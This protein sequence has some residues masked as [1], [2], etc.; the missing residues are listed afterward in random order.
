MINF[1]STKLI[2]FGLECMMNTP[3]LSESNR[4]NPFTLWKKPSGN[5][6]FSNK[7]GDNIYVDADMEELPII[8]E[9]SLAP[10]Q[11]IE[12]RSEIEVEPRRHSQDVE[13]NGGNVVDSICEM[14]EMPNYSLL[15]NHQQQ[16]KV[17]KSNKKIHKRNIDS[18][19]NKYKEMRI[20]VA[21]TGENFEKSQDCKQADSTKE[22]CESQSKNKALQTKKIQQ[23][24]AGNKDSSIS[25]KREMKLKLK[26]S[27][28]S[29]Q[30]LIESNC[31]N[32]NSS[33]SSVVRVSLRIRNK[34]SKAEEC[35]GWTWK[36]SQWIKL[37][38]ECFISKGFCSPSWSWED[39]FNM[40]ENEEEITKIRNK[41]ASRNPH[42]FKSKVKVE[43]TNLSS[44]EGDQKL[45]SQDIKTHIKGWNWKRSQW[46]N[47]Y[48]ECHQNGAKCTELW[49]WTEWKNKGE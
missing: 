11:H 18:R 3:N 25:K 15:D 27:E 24:E 8:R 45:S 21:K 6:E 1:K 7:N 30:E 14:F 9:F 42:A 5:Y 26:A 32:L 19:W 12:E 48:W 47:N 44:I 38:C 37:Y 39:W 10:H 2:K 41:I 49:A 34:E 20:K 36:K 22:K 35:K 31:Q 33:Q 29:D 43:E 4:I 13:C 28:L 17:W 46:S 16:M 23:K 40:E